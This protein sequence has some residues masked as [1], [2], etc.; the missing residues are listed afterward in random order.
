M[1]E[2]TCC[3]SVAFERPNENSFM[4]LLYCPLPPSP[5]PYVSGCCFTPLPPPFSQ[6]NR[7]ASFNW[8]MDFGTA[9]LPSLSVG[10]PE[11]GTYT[12]F[13]AGAAGVSGGEPV[14]RILIRHPLRDPEG[15]PYPPPSPS[16][17]WCFFLVCV[18][19]YSAHPE[20]TGGGSDDA[21]VLADLDVG[22]AVYNF[23]EAPGEAGGHA[24]LELAH[25]GDEHEEEED[26]PW[27]EAEEAGDLSTLLRGEWVVWSVWSW[28]VFT[29]C[30]GALPWF[31][32]CVGVCA[33]P[34]MIS[35]SRGEYARRFLDALRST[36]GSH[37]YSAEA[38]RS[39]LDSTGASDAEHGFG[40]HRPSGLRVG[41]VHPLSHPRAQANPCPP[42]TA[43]W[44]A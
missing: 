8:L 44:Q 16:T 41:L 6:N 32:A 3:S 17:P 12:G 43:F 2:K 36:G 40:L 13:G 5:P 28:C 34:G 4:Y 23:D 15:F 31:T 37:P 25:S 20:R 30:G 24:E 9:F 19:P 7:D 22:G 33:C 39:V 14:L 29:A 10:E 21:A 26:F 18:T 1:A 11:E 42:C 27:E 38:V 35:R